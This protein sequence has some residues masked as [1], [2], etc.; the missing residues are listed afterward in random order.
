MPPESP[1]EAITYNSTTAS[2]WFDL[3]GSGGCDI[4]YYT[5]EWRQW[6]SN[7]WILCDGN[8][9]PADRMYTVVGLEP[10]S[11]YQLKVVARNNIGTSLALYNFTTLT[12][13]GGVLFPRV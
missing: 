9:V 10:A 5:V 6:K 12:V 8:I 13:D 7:E 11:Q 1:T 4:Q 2:A 3:W